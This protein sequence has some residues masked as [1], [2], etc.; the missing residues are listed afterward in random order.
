MGLSNGNSQKKCLEGLKTR[1]GEKKIEQKKGKSSTTEDRK[2]YYATMYG[3][4]GW[5]DVSFPSQFWIFPHSSKL[6]IAV[7]VR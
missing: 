3:Q 1:S 4:E 6:C 7:A 5:H 2:E